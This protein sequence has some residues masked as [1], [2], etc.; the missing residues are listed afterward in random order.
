MKKARLSNGPSILVSAVW[1]ISFVIPGFIGAA[2]TCDIGAIKAK[3]AA[4]DYRPALTELDGCVL[5]KGKSR[6]QGLAYYGMFR[7]D[8][9]VFFLQI[10]SKE[11]DQDDTVLTALAE[12]ML[13]GKEKSQVRELL[14]QVKDKH[15]P[16]YCKAMASFYVSK[17]QFPKALE[18]YDQA[19]LTEKSPVTLFHKAMLLSWMNRLNESLALYTKLIE[20]DGL[21]KGFKVKCRIH[22]AEVIS[23]K[24]DL[25]QAA[26]ELRS[27]IEEEPKS[28]E[29]RLG[30]GEILEWQGKYAEAKGQYRDVLLIDPE[31]QASK[32]KLEKLLWVK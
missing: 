29:A 6:L 2:P 26:A 18:M 32:Q 15:A 4:E 24:K 19:L 27:V 7:A 10:A 5:P 17:R 8:S 25:D 31:N 30:L 23:W 3:L 13:W 11:G 14:D 12:T 16:A 28:L 9:T 22:R 20:T 1:L 21:S